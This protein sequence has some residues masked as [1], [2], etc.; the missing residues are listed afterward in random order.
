MTC[1]DVLA[2]L[3]I[4]NEKTWFLDSASNQFLR[5][6]VALLHILTKID[7]HCVHNGG[8]TPYNNGT[9]NKS[10]VHNVRY[11]TSNAV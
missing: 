1:I 2:C 9:D 11:I 7:K 4:A 5:M 3:S 8:Y 6:V 10:Y